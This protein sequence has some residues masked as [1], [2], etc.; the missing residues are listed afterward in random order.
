MKNVIPP[1]PIAIT[2]TMILL[3]FLSA[4]SRAALIDGGDLTTIDQAGNPSDGLRFLDMSYSDG[5]SKTAALANAQGTYA[6]ARLATPS[7]LNDLV[8]A[9]TLVLNGGTTPSD[10]WVVGADVVI[11][12][13]WRYNTSVRDLLGPTA[14]VSF[15]N[16]WTDP[17]GSH[18]ASTT[19]DYLSF[20]AS[21]LKGQQ[22]SAAIHP[23]IGWF[24]VSAGTVVPEPSSFILLAAC[25]LGL[26]C[27]RIR[28]RR[29]APPAT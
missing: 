5:L 26:A 17:D 4:S 23:S 14:G 22:I 12:S 6:D 25:G 11:S 27:H 16:G 19:R 28:R 21:D 24:I 13:T 2:S 9:S 3:L 29:Q 1:N 8:A 7:E 10:A 18:V 20:G 15:M